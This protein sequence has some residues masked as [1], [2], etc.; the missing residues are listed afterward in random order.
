MIILIYGNG[1]TAIS[2]K[3]SEIKNK[4]DPNS[5]QEFSGK[6][7]DFDQAVIQFST[8]GLFTEEKLVI[9][10]DFE[11]ALDES[12]LKKIEEIAGDPDTTVVL[13]FPKL[14]ASSVLL[15]RLNQKKA[16]VINLTEANEENLFPFLDKLADK[17]P[18]VMKE[19]NGRIEESSGQYIL[20][21]IFYM[22]RRMVMPNPKLPSFVQQKIAKQKQNF[23]G[24]KIAQLYK[25]GLET[26]YKIKSGLTDEKMGI[27]LLV[28]NIL[29]I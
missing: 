9:L 20:T 6:Q 26:D 1:L 5:I 17:N 25:E 22:L 11:A 21:M 3:I 15:K 4:F 19:L 12:Q 27:T 16:Q 14:L 2:K 24:D 29:T 23:P 7:I 13:K 10:Q 28:N 18:Q 8:G